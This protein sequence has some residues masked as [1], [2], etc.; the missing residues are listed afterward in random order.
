MYI[1]SLN[2]T[3]VEPKEK[4]KPKKPTGDAPTFTE[5][6]K[7]Q[8]LMNDNFNLCCLSYNYSAVPLPSDRTFMVLF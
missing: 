6:L 1:I 7:D 2:F 5:K 4:P 8:V 3:V